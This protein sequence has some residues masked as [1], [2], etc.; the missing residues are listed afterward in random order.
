MDS[1]PLAVGIKPKEKDAGNAACIVDV[2]QLSVIRGNKLILKDIDFKIQKG[3]F[4]GIVGPNGGGKTTLLLSILGILKPSKGKIKLFGN[5]PMSK[6]LDGKISWVSQA[7]SNIPNDLRVTV[8]E[9]VALGTIN[10]KNM[11][12][13]WRDNKK[14]EQVIDMVGLR[15]V[16]KIDI[17]RLSGGQRQ[18]AVIGRAL[19]SDAEIIILD[20][21]LVGID[22]EAKNA[23]L[24]LLDDLCHTEE[25]TII[26][27]SHD[28][29]AVRHTTHRMVYLEGS[30]RFDGIPPDFPTLEELA[31]LRGIKDVHGGHH[32][33]HSEEDCDGEHD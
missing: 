2:D 1:G 15:D 5:K 30:I 23:L 3:E 11:F 32:Y 33:D 8:R 21:P 26:M 28:L 24:K 10:R 12:W 25:K 6:N 4:I 22:R 31:L 14:V 18:R 17:G 9:L 27:V 13:G 16:S 19:A 20:E 29:A 7:A